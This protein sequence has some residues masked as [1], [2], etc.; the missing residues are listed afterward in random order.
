MSN[1]VITTQPQS[2]GYTSGDTLH[3]EDLTNT[4]NEESYSGHAN[5]VLSDLDTLK[6]IDF[7][8]VQQQME[9]DL[10][11]KFPGNT[12]DISLRDKERKTRTNWY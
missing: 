10:K 6:D 2:N 8:H 1:I 7:L 3:L 4:S 12:S 11:G 5:P 9:F